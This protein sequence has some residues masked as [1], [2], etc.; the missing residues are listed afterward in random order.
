MTSS[1]HSAQRRPDPWVGSFQT[2]PQAKITLFCFPY[3]G[4][5]SLIYRNWQASFPPSVAVCPVQLPGRGARLHEAAF[6]DLFSLVDATAEALAPH[7]KP[8]FAFFGHSMGARIGF[9]LAR[10]LR[11]KGRPMPEHLFVSGC[12]APQI[13]D[14]DPPTYNLPEPEF[15]EELGRLNG[16]PKDV[17]EH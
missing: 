6:K 14:N 3:A 7:L 13:V 9:E 15:I 12:R 5:T 1:H 4:G 10:L 17:L 16:T 2:S 8:P 11:H